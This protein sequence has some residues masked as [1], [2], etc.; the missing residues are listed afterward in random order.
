MGSVVSLVSFRVNN[1]LS[2]GNGD[3]V[4]LGFSANAC[5]WAV[6]SDCAWAGGVVCPGGA[7]A[8]VP[9]PPPPQAL[10]PA[11]VNTAVVKAARFFMED[12]IRYF[13][14]SLALVGDPG[15]AVLR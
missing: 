12:V 11:A 10:K 2:T 3:A 9:L 1:P 7:A 13:L 4:S 6:S 15:S 5:T 14:Q 8:S